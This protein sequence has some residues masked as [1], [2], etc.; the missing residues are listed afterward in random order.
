MPRTPKRR[1]TV[2]Y[3]RMPLAK[4]LRSAELA[5]RCNA[6]VR[7]EQGDLAVSALS[8]A[9]HAAAFESA[10][11]DRLQIGDDQHFLAD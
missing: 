7:D 4:F 2:Q 10:E 1:V 8:G 5:A 11:L 6:V 9:D 3:G